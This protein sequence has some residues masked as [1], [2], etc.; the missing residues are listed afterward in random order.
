MRRSIASRA[1]WKAVRSLHRL[2]SL[3]ISPGFRQYSRRPTGRSW[4]TGPPRAMS[5]RAVVESLPAETTVDADTVLGW[6][7]R[8]VQPRIEAERLFEKIGLSR[9]LGSTGRGRHPVRGH[10][11]VTAANQ[12]ATRMRRRRVDPVDVGG[13][14][15]EYVVSSPLV[16]WHLDSGWPKRWNFSFRSSPVAAASSAACSFGEP[17]VFSST[18]WCSVTS[19]AT[20]TR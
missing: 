7:W 5:S 18:S 14:V 19:R 9:L 8:R 11:G 13:V 10:W 15:V 2:D 6:Y 12:R 1:S 20:V 16:Y 17:L 3:P 4:R